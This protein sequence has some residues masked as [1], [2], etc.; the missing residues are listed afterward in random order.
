MGWS[1]LFCLPNVFVQ[2]YIVAR[3]LLNCAIN[4][5]ECS[6]V[7]ELYRREIWWYLI[8]RIHNNVMIKK[9]SLNNFCVHV[10]AVRGTRQ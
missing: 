8:H 5:L 1:D 3:A 10:E 6:I 2:I 4:F 9:A 7:I